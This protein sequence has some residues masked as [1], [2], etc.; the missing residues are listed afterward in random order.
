MARASRKARPTMPPTTPPAI[1]AVSDLVTDLAVSSADGGDVFDVGTLSGI[2][3]EM[4]EPCVV[5]VSRTG[6]PDAFGVSVY[7]S[8]ADGY[9]VEGGPANDKYATTSGSKWRRL[10]ARSL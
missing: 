4:A 7:M 2:D 10:G 5:D 8:V 3:A 1:A 9:A 6:T